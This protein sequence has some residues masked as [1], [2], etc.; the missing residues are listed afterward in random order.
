[1]A[2]G[3]LKKGR[4]RSAQTAAVSLLAAFIVV[5]GA[6]AASGGTIGLTA[7]FRGGDT[8][9]GIDTIAAAR[10]RFPVGI[11]AARQVKARRPH[12]RRHP[13]TP[14]PGPT[15]PGASAPTEPGT[16]PP[17]GPDRKSTRLN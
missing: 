11:E 7:A 10:Q 6:D 14:S 8:S 12:H 5:A 3:S 17:A 4:F 2:E 9:F 13:V 1:M 16:L 15:R